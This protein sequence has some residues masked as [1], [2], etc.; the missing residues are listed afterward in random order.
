MVDTHTIGQIEW[1]RL[2]TLSDTQRCRDGFY[3]TTQRNI[4][5]K[6]RDGEFCVDGDGLFS[7]GSKIGQPLRLFMPSSNLYT[8][9]ERV[10]PSSLDARV[11]FAAPPFEHCPSITS[12]REF[13]YGSVLPQLKRFGE[14]YREWVGKPVNGGRL[15]EMRP[16]LDEFLM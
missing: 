8:V 13:E 9:G 1:V 11:L 14:L 4:L 5:L 12:V 3:L 7:Y 10:F 2:Y 15:G 16:R 6:N